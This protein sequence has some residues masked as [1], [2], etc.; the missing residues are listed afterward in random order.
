MLNHRAIILT[1]VLISLNLLLGCQED[2]S[3]TPAA[4]AKSEK[5]SVNI[6]TGTVIESMDVAGYTYVQVGVNGEKIWMAGPKTTITQGGTIN[7]DTRAPMKNFHS[8][9]LNRDFPV[10][11][12]V[13][14]FSGSAVQIDAAAPSTAATDLPAGHI[15]VA[16]LG[17]MPDQK[18]SLNQ[19]VERAEGGK[20]IAEVIANK[21]ELSGKV[22]KVRGKVTK[23]TADVMTKNWIHI[24][25][26]S[27]DNDLTV[28]TDQIVAAGQMIVIEG[29][30]LLDKDYGYGYVYELLIDNAKVTVE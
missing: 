20:T 10:I 22:V 6:T 4:E 2:A 30:V 5:N 18:P 11:Y 3:Q 16:G 26:G 21:K 27:G 24:I 23:F 29:T 19:P 28:I 14:S 13:D 15:P 7:S 8:K 12:F 1:S 9:A 17:T 25:D